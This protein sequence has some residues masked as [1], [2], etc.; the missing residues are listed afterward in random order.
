MEAA[1]F[2]QICNLRGERWKAG[3]GAH[4]SYGRDWK[5][6]ISTE[7][8]KTPFLL[9]LAEESLAQLHP[10]NDI[11]VFNKSGFENPQRGPQ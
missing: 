2:L 4:G 7:V 11:I 9:K 6:A 1:S 10:L 8:I 5:R 3:S